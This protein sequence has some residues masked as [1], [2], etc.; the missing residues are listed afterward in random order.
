L[1]RKLSRVL[2][3][4]QVPVEAPPCHLGDRR[5]IIGAAFP[6]GVPD[7][8][9]AVVRLARQPVLEHHQRRHHIGALHMADVDALDA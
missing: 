2:D 4:V 9:V 3:V 1:C 5:H 6:R 7:R 8:V